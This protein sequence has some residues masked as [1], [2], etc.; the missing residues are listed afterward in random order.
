M[1]IAVTVWNDDEHEGRGAPSF[2][3][4]Y[5]PNTLK[6]VRKELEDVEALIAMQPTKAM[7]ERWRNIYLNATI[8]ALRKSE[9][10][11]LRRE[12]DSGG[13]VYPTKQQEIPLDAPPAATAPSSSPQE[14][15]AQARFNKMRLISFYNKHDRKMVAS[16]DAM[17]E[18]H[19]GKEDELFSELEEKYD[20]EN[21][22][23]PW[24]IEFYMKRDTTML[25]SVDAI[26]R[27]H[28]D[29]EWLLFRMLN[30]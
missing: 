10:D 2:S 7:Q 6:G 1:R 4:I 8:R 3:T 9:S 24:L 18:E 20:E 23:K 27:N 14:A 11:M 5:V 21:F 30:N 22:T 25:D 15:A 19:A 29:N 12:M 28:K 17:L 13:F 26:L 16:V